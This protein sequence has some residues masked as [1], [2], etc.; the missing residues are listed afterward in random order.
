VTRRARL[1]L[2]SAIAGPVIGL[3]A[4][5]VAFEHQ[6]HIP[7]PRISDPDDLIAARFGAAAPV[8]TRPPISST[9]AAGSLGRTP[10]RRPTASSSS[11]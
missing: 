2:S 7:Y 5:G 11:L 6:Y 3:L 9:A 8:A 10:A 4:A 1:V